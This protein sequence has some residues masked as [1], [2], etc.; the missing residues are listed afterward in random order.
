MLNVLNFAFF[1]YQDTCVSSNACP[2]EYYTSTP[3]F[4]LVAQLSRIVC[5][6]C[7]SECSICDGPSN[8]DCQACKNAFQ[9][10]SGSTIDQCLSSCSNSTDD[11]D[12]CFTCHPQC[13]GCQGTTNQDC[14]SC[15]ES[16]VTNTQTQQTI[17]VGQCETGQYLNTSLYSCQP[18]ASQCISCDGPK[19][20]QC[21]QCKGATMLVGG[22]MVCVSSCPN[23]MYQSSTGMCVNCHEQCSGGCSG[24]TNQDCNVCA[25]N[26][27]LSDNVTLCV[28]DCPFA[29]NFDVD[30][31]D[32]V[33]S[34]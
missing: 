29:H 6:P 8:S 3:S 31:N 20:T 26:S 7:H 23:G 16:N 22:S 21:Q 2:Q 18:C 1:P 14:L 13:N 11:S 4:P 10:S 32:C 9:S 33:L 28:S 24:P 19:N 5:S 25:S 15:K 27:V 12:Q 17:C 34:K 30:A